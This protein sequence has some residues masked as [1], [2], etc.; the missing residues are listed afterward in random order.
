MAEKIRLNIE[1]SMKIPENWRLRSDFEKNWFRSKIGEKRSKKSGRFR[2]K[3]R[4]LQETAFG[5]KSY[6]FPEKKK[7]KP[8][9]WRLR[10]K[11]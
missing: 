8:E 6:L 3:I 4:A 9:N 11:K 2:S 5:R 7:D 1:E 10:S